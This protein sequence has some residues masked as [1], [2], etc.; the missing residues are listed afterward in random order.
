MS[1]APSA[2]ADRLAAMREVASWFTVGSS[3]RSALEDGADRIESLSAQ[4]ASAREDAAQLRDAL[5]LIID[6]WDDGKLPEQDRC[7][8]HGAFTSSIDDARSAIAGAKQGEGN[9]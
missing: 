8:S 6:V 3:E 7:Y 2:D 1:E 4:L 5:E 9:G